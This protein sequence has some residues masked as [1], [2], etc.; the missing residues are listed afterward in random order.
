MSESQKE[1]TEFFFLETLRRVLDLSGKG[2][3]FF[4]V[5]R[6][7]APRPFSDGDA[8]TLEVLWILILVWTIP[9][10]TGGEVLQQ[11]RFPRGAVELF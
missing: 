3:S 2:L 10:R 11:G 5:K 1:A 6:R 9:G 7:R 4:N 8:S